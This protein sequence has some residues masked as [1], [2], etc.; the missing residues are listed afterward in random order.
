MRRSKRCSSRASA[1]TLSGRTK[2][3]QRATGVTRR[4][5]NR[6][7]PVCPLYSLSLS[8]LKILTSQFE[9]SNLR[10]FQSTNEPVIAIRHRLEKK[11]HAL[12]FTEPVGRFSVFKPNNKPLS[13][14]LRLGLSSRHT[15]RSVRNNNYEDTDDEDSQIP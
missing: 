11:L 14:S 3:S 8:G 4:C 1:S 6:V 2:R 15:L 7:A 12:L 9:T 5:L 13:A 10:I